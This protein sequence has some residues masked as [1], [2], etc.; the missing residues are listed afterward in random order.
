MKLRVV[1]PVNPQRGPC[2]IQ[3]LQRVRKLISEAA[4][5][6]RHLYSSSWWNISFFFFYRRNGIR[7]SQTPLTSPEPPALERKNKIEK[8]KKTPVKHFWKAKFPTAVVVLIRQMRSVGP[9]GLCIWLHKVCCVEHP[10]VAEGLTSASLVWHGG[11]AVSQPSSEPQPLS[12]KMLHYRVPSSLSQAITCPEPGRCSH[13]G[14]PRRL[15]RRRNTPAA[16]AALIKGWKTFH[17]QSS[18]DDVS[19]KRKEKRKKESTRNNKW[20]C[21][22]PGRAAEGVDQPAC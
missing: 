17:G 10:S 12:S 6:K 7:R 8:K 3:S 16:R 4:A 9:E 19:K 11:G 13:P 21:N 1:M 22:T 18:S 20:D 2:L 15:R 14:R 5:S